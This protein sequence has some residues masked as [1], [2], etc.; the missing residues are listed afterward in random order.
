[1]SGGAWIGTVVVT[2]VVVMIAMLSMGVGVALGR[3]QPRGT[4]GGTGVD[5]CV[6]DPRTRDCEPSKETR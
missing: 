3:R 1:V 4:C 5:G 2:T 6:C